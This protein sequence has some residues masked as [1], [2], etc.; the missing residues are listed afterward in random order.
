MEVHDTV[1][2]QSTLKWDRHSI[3]K[4]LIAALEIDHIV[5]EHDYLEH[6]Q[7]PNSDHQRFATDAIGWLSFLGPD[8]SSMVQK[9][10]WNGGDVEPCDI[11]AGESPLDALADILN[12]RGVVV[13]EPPVIVPASGWQHEDK[14]IWEL[15]RELLSR[16]EDAELLV[17]GVWSADPEAR[18]RELELKARDWPAKVKE[19]RMRRERYAQ[20]VEDVVRVI[21]EAMQAVAEGMTSADANIKI[22]VE[23]DHMIIVT[24]N[25][26]YRRAVEVIPF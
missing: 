6:V 20:R 7:P 2:R 25:G 13:F 8:Q 1:S 10:L 9:W 5:T 23:G 15:S 24:A 22:D 17:E 12:E 3:E 26:V 11:A 4:A 16:C 14:S 21:V 19:R 18:K